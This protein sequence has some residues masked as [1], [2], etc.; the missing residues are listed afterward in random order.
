MV[1]ATKNVGKDTNKRGPERRPN[2]FRTAKLLSSVAIIGTLAACGGEEE[3]APSMPS[4]GSA[5]V[6]G[7]V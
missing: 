6:A 5:G 4:D 2:G 1:E 3:K 7:A